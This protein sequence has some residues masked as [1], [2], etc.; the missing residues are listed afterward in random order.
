LQFARFRAVETRRPI[1]RVAN[2]GVTAWFD[3]L[4]NIRSATALFREAVVV[5]DI[6]P[7]TGLTFY[8]RHPQLVPHLSAL[9]LLLAALGLFRRRSQEK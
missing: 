9:A 6:A 1:V 2:T 5:T 4:G 8:V 7:G 3:P